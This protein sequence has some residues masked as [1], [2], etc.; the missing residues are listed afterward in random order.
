MSIKPIIVHYHIFKNAGTSVDYALKN[1]F[2]NFWTSFE[3]NS[4]ID[5]LPMA[6]LK[7]FLDANP[8]I[9]AVSSHLAR[10]PLPY[11]NSLP[12]LFL[13]HPILRAKSVYEFVKKDNTQPNHKFALNGFCEYI[14]WALFSDSEGGVVIKNY[15][16]IHLSDASFRTT[17]ILNATAQPADLRQAEHLL[18]SWPAFGIVE[19]YEKSMA[20]FQKCYGDLIDGLQ[21]SVAWLNKS[22]QK[23]INPNVSI[24][25][26]VEAICKVLG[27]DLFDALCSANN[28]D[29]N[30]YHRCKKRFEDNT[31]DF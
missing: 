29:L 27:N 3:G 6:K 19:S 30:L 4:P 11:K 9:D 22:D 20:L 14:R 23:N 21:L 8:A 25:A 28:L 31:A 16:V 26:Q 2:G 12:I 1:T 10:P 7:A 24:E 5:I 18:F 17:S 13:R 15:Q